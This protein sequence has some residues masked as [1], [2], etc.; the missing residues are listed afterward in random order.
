MVK[1]SL[2]TIVANIFLTM[3]ANDFFLTH[4]GSGF[5]EQW[6]HEEQR[7]VL[8]PRPARVLVQ[9]RPAPAGTD[10][11]NPRGRTRILRHSVFVIQ[12]PGESVCKEGVHELGVRVAR[13][14]GLWAWP[15][16]GVVCGRDA[17][18]VVEVA[19]VHAALPQQDGGDHH[20]SGREEG[21]F[22]YC[23]IN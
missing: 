15:A 13:G 7:Q 17:G 16:A 20:D 23:I 11:K 21:L 8:E 12:G 3:H 9:P 19:Y 1:S 10:A 18:L 6:R 2:L 22:R 4:F 14:R 5:G